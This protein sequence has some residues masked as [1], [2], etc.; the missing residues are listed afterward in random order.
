MDYK[1]PFSPWKYVWMFAQ[2]YG[3]PLVQD[4]TARIDDPTVARAY[5]AYFGFLAKDKIVSPDAV[6]WAS[7][8]ATANFASGKSAMFAMTSASV[9][10]TLAKSRVASSYAFT[11]MP[12]VPPGESA[13]PAGGV[14][15]TTIVSGQ[16]L[17]VASYSTQQDLAL[18]YLDLVTSEA[19]QQHFSEVFG[20]LP[21]NAA[22]A[23][24][25]ASGKEQYAPVLEA[26]KQAK[27]TPFTGAWSE[28]QLGL[29]N[30]TVQALAGLSTGSVPPDEVQRQLTELQQTAQT[31]VDKAAA[32]R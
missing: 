32:A 10:P 3:N 1:D 20:V 18:Q 19:E 7:A 24:A 13:L 6:N 25:V 17:V 31:A 12:A 26:G 30:I 28:I 29:T 27:P 8:D 23:E 16:N 21:V 9:I 5:D 2:Q 4:T 14:P 22:A 15:A 11:P